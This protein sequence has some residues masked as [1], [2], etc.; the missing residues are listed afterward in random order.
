MATGVHAFARGHICVCMQQGAQIDS[1]YL[2]LCSKYYIAV[3]LTAPVITA[4]IIGLLEFRHE[5]SKLNRQA[6][7]VNSSSKL[8]IPIFLRK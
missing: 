8:E 3:G 4:I 5:V 6:S 1:P 2:L 7:S